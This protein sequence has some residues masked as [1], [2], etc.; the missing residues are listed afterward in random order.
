MYNSTGT[1]PSRT[2]TQVSPSSSEFVAINNT[3]DLSAL[4]LR[5]RPPKRI[6]RTS[7]DLTVQSPVDASS[8]RYRPSIELP[9]FAD[10][11]KLPQ[12]STLT[13]HGDVEDLDDFEDQAQGSTSS[14][15]PHTKLA[16]T[17]D[18]RVTKKLYRHQKPRF[19]MKTSAGNR[20]KIPI[21]SKPGA[22]SKPASKV[23]K[24][25]SF[26]R[27]KFASSNQLPGFTTASNSLR[28]KPPPEDSK[29]QR[30]T[31]CKL[32]ENL[33]SNHQLQGFT[34]ASKLSRTSFAPISSAIQP[35]K[36]SREKNIEQ[37]LKK[38]KNHQVY[39]DFV[40]D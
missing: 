18:S 19:D 24:P 1:T 25:Q 28:S 27:K 13:E 36:K 10:T 31:G 12:T 8:Y 40:F 26:A 21:E 4:N 23:I 37:R 30:F 39:Q 16:I 29:S 20:L 7:E 5:R 2:S 3:C 14:R 32:K 22:S 17:R 11:S 6:K 38:R 34:A 15:L 35:G 9:G 33:P